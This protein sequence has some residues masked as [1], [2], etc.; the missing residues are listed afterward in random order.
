MLSTQVRRHRN[1]DQVEDR[2]KEKAIEE[3]E[4]Q[5]NILRD[6]TKED[7]KDQRDHERYRD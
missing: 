7:N 1:N 6:T 3:H 5:P 4:C 2:A